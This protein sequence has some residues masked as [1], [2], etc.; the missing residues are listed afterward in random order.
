MLKR[1]FFLFFLTAFIWS[2]EIISILGE[3]VFWKFQVIDKAISTYG[4]TT[5][6][7]FILVSVLTYGFIW[8]FGMFYVVGFFDR[9]F[10]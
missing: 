7:I 10:E 1:C 5:G 2:I 4:T 3:D 9:W 6:D 8:G